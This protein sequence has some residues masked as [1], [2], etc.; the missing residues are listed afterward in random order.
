LSYAREA[1]YREVVM[2]AALYEAAVAPYIGKA[3]SGWGPVFVAKSR[4]YRVRTFVVYVPKDDLRYV[5]AMQHSRFET[6]DEAYAAAAVLLD[7]HS[8]R[9][10][11]QGWW[12]TVA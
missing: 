4:S 2:S 7:S 1:R 10:D 9:L 6:L 8:Y 3:D 12:R 5:G 11:S